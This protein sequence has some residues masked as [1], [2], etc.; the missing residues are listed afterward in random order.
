MPKSKHVKINMKW[1]RFFLLLFLIPSLIYASFDQKD[2]AKIVDTITSEWNRHNELVQQSINLGTNEKEKRVAL[3]NEAVACCQR[4]IGLCDKILNKI[5]NNTK[6]ERHSSWCVEARKK[7]EKDK[8]SLNTEIGN[9]QNALNTT[10]KN[11]AFE[12]AGQLYQESE[13]KAGLAFAKSKNCPRRLNNVEAVTS[14]LNEIGRLYDEASMADKEA[15]NLISPYSEETSNNTLKKAVEIYQTAASKYKQEAAEWPAAAL[16][17]KAILR[18]RLAALKEDRRLFEVKGLKRSS[19]EIQK[20]TLSILEQL[21]E[22]S[23]DDEEL[24]QLKQSIAA[25]EKE[26]DINR[27]TEST[28]LI[29][30]EEFSVREKERRELF[31]KSDLILNPNLFLQ[32]ILQNESGPFA[33]PLD[34]Q[35]VKKGKNFTLYTDQFYRFLVQ[36]DAPISELLIKVYERGKIIHEEK[37]P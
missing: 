32:S 9:L 20:Q 4:A 11:I 3:L 12:K 5:A 26:A 18:E 22:G 29:S 37:I 14:T 8:K 2:H 34:G 1:T 33:I 13:K 27:L 31:F 36:K 16:A 10:F 7:S 6:A 24:T 28:H 21:I 23:I 25:F 17:Q 19:Y 15:L 30:Q 35:V